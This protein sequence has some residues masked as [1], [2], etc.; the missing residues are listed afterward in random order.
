MRGGLLRVEEGGGV[1]KSVNSI[2]YLAFRIRI[3]N[4]EGQRS[5]AISGKKVG[6]RDESDAVPFTEP[7]AGNGSRYYE[8]DIHPLP[9]GRE[10]D[11]PPHLFPGYVLDGHE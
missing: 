4:Q 10:N 5:N 9:Y 1:P 2:L 8:N 3:F 6:E 7:T 11:G